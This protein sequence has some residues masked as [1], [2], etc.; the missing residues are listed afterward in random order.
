[1]QN[2]IEKAR[3]LLREA[4]VAELCAVM[5]AER[6]YREL[7]SMADELKQLRQTELMDQVLYAK[8]SPSPQF[9]NQL[10]KMATFRQVCS[11]VVFHGGGGEFTVINRMHWAERQFSGMRGGLCV[12]QERGCFS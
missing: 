9:K 4:E 1:M 10:S 3:R 6:N 11:R 7:G 5:Q 8:S 12:S 2:P